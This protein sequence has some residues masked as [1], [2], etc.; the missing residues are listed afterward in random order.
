VTEP[1][2]CESALHV[3]EHAALV[4]QVMAQLLATLQPWELVLMLMLDMEEDLLSAELV[5]GLSELAP[6]V[7]LPTFGLLSTLD[8]RDVDPLVRLDA[9]VL[10][11]LVE[12]G[13]DASRALASAPASAPY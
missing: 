12:P 11:R 6:V 9:C 4:G 8:M 5:I 2:H 7:E 3:N 1:A 10:S 13:P